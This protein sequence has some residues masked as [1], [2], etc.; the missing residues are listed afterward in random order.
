M[1]KETVL[2]TGGTGLVGTHL[3]LKLAQ[4]GKNIRAL[5][6]D[7]SNLDAVKKVFDFYDSSV[8]FTSISWVNGDITDIHSLM[9]AMEG[10]DY[11]YHTAA[12]VSFNPKDQQK[13]YKINIE[14]TA[15]VVN[16]CI[17]AGIKKLCYTSSTAAIGKSKGD[18]IVTE[19]NKWDE[20]EV[21]SNY[22]I[23]KHFAENEVWRGIAEGLS[24][25]MVNPCVVIGP[26]DISRSSG[27]L[28]G[29]IKKG[30][31]FYTSGA[32]AFVDA[33]DVA[34]AMV[35][36]LESD[37]ESERFLL[38]GENLSYQTLF[39]KIAHSLGVKAPS[40]LVK[41]IL[42]DLSW[43]VEKIRSFLTQKPPVVTSESA[44]SAIST[45]RF[46]AQK[47]ITA[48]GFKFRTMDDAVGNAGAFFRK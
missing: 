40:I 41:G 19:K 18:E 45:T 14:G 48:T 2:V 46:S 43:R 28:F 47:M 21:T 26:G 36:L 38:I 27:T 4:T 3:L 5:K 35:L 31:K 23:S 7:N 24:S 8:L 17:E 1:Q 33:R 32:N 6:R 34:D 12:L 42:V 13:L 20:E 16:A 9:E 30:L 10:I 15:N 22:S 37:I 25:V 39:A 11:V 44:Q 29:T